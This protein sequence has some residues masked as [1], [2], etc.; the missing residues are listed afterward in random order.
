[1]RRLKSILLAF[2]ILISLLG[3]HQ[4]S[5]DGLPAQEAREIEA[6]KIE[7]IGTIWKV[8]G[9][10]TA[11]MGALGSVSTLVALASVSE[12][13]LEDQWYI[14]VSMAG[15]NLGL[16]AFGIWEISHGNDL[17]EKALQIRRGK[18][19]DE[20]QLKKKFDFI[21]PERK[22]CGV[23]IPGE[24]QPCGARC[25]TQV[26]LP[27]CQWGN[28]TSKAECAPGETR[29]CGK[30]GIQICLPDCQWR[31][32]RLEDGVCFPGETKFCRENKTQTCLPDCQWDECN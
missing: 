30:C 11:M 3:P 27:S 22:K 20:Q 6:L 7:E 14:Y 12:S 28:C 32:C 16:L 26:C 9:W 25:G 18:Y 19:S 5:G 1:M 31:E 23:C 15:V 8:F 24:T 17:K 29:V 21:L 2:V 10:P 4:S 13:S